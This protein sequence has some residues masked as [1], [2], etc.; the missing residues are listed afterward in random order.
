MPLAKI[1]VRKSRPAH[2]VQGLIDAVYEAQRS[3]IQLKEGDRQVRYIEHRP[4]HF[5]VPAHRSD[6]FTVVEITLFPGRG[7]AAKRALYA[8]I[9]E[10]FAA[11]G[12]GA[13][14]LY[15]VLHEVTPENWGLRGV[16]G[17]ELK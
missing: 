2:E 7:S 11:F 14:D 10:R 8:G 15:I 4:E 16:P 9:A 6:N 3:A 17:S 12:I 13:D 5:A 1:E